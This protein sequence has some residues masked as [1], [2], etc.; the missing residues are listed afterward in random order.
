MSPACT[1]LSCFSKTNNNVYTLNRFELSR[2]STVVPGTLSSLNKYYFSSLLVQVAVFLVLL[3]FFFPSGWCSSLLSLSSSCSWYPCPST[4]Q[5]STKWDKKE[6][7]EIWKWDFSKVM[8]VL[9]LPPPWK[10]DIKQK[11][12]S[13]N[14]FALGDFFQFSHLEKGTYSTS[15]LP[16]RSATVSTAIP[17]SLWD[18][19]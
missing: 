8:W 17:S 11:M 14:L 4:C 1:W 3:S 2:F 9:S 19:L 13:L 18:R 7:E 10:T 12:A 16:A 6:E 5:L 15:Q